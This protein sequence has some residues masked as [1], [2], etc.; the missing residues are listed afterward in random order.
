MTEF[1]ARDEFAEFEQHRDWLDNLTWTCHVCGDERPDTA[2]SVFKREHT[3]AV[4]FTE[5]IRYC[6]DR[7]ACIE[8]ARTFSHL[9]GS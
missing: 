6:N 9:K 3:G 5:N 2:I 7:P 1:T 8:G 4:A